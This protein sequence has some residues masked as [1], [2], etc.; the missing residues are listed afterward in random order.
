MT[1]FDLAREQA[2]LHSI[3]ETLGWDQETY[4]PPAANRHRA[5]Q[6]AWLSAKAHE[7]VT[8]PAWQ[9]ALGQA[10]QADDGSD[11]KL[12]ANLRELRRQFDRETKLPTELVARESK[13]SS[14]AKQ[15]WAKAREDNDFP[16]FADHLD[17]LLGIARE[18]A[19]LWGYRDGEE[20]L[21]SHY[22]MEKPG[23]QA[24]NG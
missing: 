10:E 8:S 4:M 24:R 11:P 6:L 5:E 7:M 20:W 23:A 21:V 2:L 17:T 13:A 3:A 12:T 18:K 16:A 15:A 14:L 1:I 19:E 22:L 9:D